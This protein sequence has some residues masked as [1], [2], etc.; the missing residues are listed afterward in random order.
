MLRNTITVEA[1]NATRV[2]ERDTFIFAK[3]PY[4][5]R[6]N[7]TNVDFIFGFVFS[8]KKAAVGFSLPLTKKADMKKERTRK[9]TFNKKEIS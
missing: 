7:K 6:A 2:T 1:S 3:P 8:K 4:T 5:R 9:K